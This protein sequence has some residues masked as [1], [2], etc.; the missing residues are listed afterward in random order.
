MDI[1]V[2]KNLTIRLPKNLR[3]GLDA[4]ANKLELTTNSY[5]KVSLYTILDLS[6]FKVKTDIKLNDIIS[7]IPS[8]NESRIH[9]LISDELN[10]L[11]RK[12]AKKYNISVNKLV[13]SAIMISLKSHAATEKTTNTFKE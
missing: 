9:F 13:L 5:I 10:E 6:P 8:G 11:L 1:A 12:K 4:A 3:G 7:D 2:D